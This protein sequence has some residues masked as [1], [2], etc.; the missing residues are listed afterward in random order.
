MPSIL[1]QMKALARNALANIPDEVCQ[2]WLYD[3]VAN[4]GWPP[5]GLEWQGY[6]FGQ[7]LAYWQKLTWHEQSV[8]IGVENLGPISMELVTNL[9]AA[10]EQGIDNLVN[11][12]MPDSK[13]RYESINRY[14]DEH[15]Q[16]PGKIVLLE[17]D[18]AYEV[19]DGAHRVTAALVYQTKNS[20]VPL[21]M[22]AWIAKII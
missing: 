18:G 6:F 21:C 19:I 17:Q 10:H 15:A 7:P 11:A 8:S 16:I 12:Y 22:E 3:R 14:L 20:G 2:L 9:V 5:V 13:D 4:S 1:E